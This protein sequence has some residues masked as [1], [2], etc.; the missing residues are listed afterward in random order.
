MFNYFQFLD[1]NQLDDLLQ[2]GRFPFSPQLFWDAELQS[3]DLQKHSRYVIER[4]VTRGFLA[5]FYL[6]QKIY[7][8]DQIRLALRQ[9]KSL[10]K[11]TR[12]FCS[13]YFQIP[14]SEL[15]VSSFYS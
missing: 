2:S 8:V 15:H 4:I 1:T 10:D 9:S 14:Q 5:D 12:H 3:V 6:L 11:K 7:T 13:W